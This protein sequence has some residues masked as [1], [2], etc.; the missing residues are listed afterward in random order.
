MI[1]LKRDL[2]KLLAGCIQNCSNILNNTY[3]TTSDFIGEIAK[4]AEPVN[5]Q[6]ERRLQRRR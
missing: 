5:G 2:E 4:P 3:N 6:D 1:C